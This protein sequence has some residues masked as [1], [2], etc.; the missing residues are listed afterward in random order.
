MFLWLS[1]FCK[2]I[3]SSSF[4]FLFYGFKDSLVISLQAK[5]SFSGLTLITLKQ[6]AKPPLPRNS[7]FMYFVL[8]WASYMIKL[9]RSLISTSEAELV[10]NSFF[11]VKVD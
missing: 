7:A 10:V 3:S 4:S 6:L 11:F 8:V 2:V 9:S 1:S 5:T